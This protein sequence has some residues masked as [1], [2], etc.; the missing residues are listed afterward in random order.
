MNFQST[1]I[2][3]Q[4]IPI[5]VPSLP[6]AFDG[7]RIAHISD[8]HLKGSSPYAHI[9]SQTVQAQHPDIIL[10]TGDTVHN[11]VPVEQSGLTAFL[12]VLCAICPVYAITGNHELR[13]GDSAFWSNWFSALGAMP[14]DN[15][16]TFLVR[17][18]ARI[19][20]MGLAGNDRF[21]QALLADSLPMLAEVPRLLLCHRPEYWEH[22]CAT[23][24]AI[25]PAITFSGHAHGGQVRLP[26]LG[27]LFAPGQGFLPRYTSGLYENQACSLVVSRGL[28]DDGKPPRINNRPHLPVVILTACP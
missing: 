2:D 10:L 11:Y 8:V 14:L 7:F 3:V 9:I 26:L 19:A 13:G 15:R 12:S 24:N 5:Q 1:R 25:K 23:G 18:A 20:L 6:A 16:C 4:T 21:S 17:G 28:V 22:T 27:G